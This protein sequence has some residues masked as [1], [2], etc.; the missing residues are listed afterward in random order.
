M[1]SELARPAFA[2]RPGV[3]QGKQMV[4]FRCGPRTLAARCV[5][6]YTTWPAYRHSTPHG[7]ATAG[8]PSLAPNFKTAV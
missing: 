1:S 6:P 4:V 2:I 8:T 3:M 5:C 7:Y